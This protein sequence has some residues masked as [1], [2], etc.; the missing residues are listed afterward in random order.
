M[1]NFIVIYLMTLHR[2]LKVYNGL[3]SLFLNI[4]FSGT[5]EGKPNNVVCKKNI[6]G[7]VKLRLARLQ[8]IY[9]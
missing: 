8:E 3:H 4:L 6:V 2:L 7:S 9:K 5:R 1:L